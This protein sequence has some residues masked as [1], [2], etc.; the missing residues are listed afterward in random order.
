MRRILARKGAAAV[1]THATVRIHND[2][3]AG[4]ASVTVGSANHESAGRIDMVLGVRIHHIRRNDGVNHVLSHLLAQFF[5]GHAVV[6][7]RRNDHGVDPRRFAVDVF[8]T[9]LA[10][11]VGT[12][13][14][15]FT[16]A[17][18]ITEAA[19][20][21]V[22]QRNGQRHQFRR[23]V[24]SVSEHQALVAGAASVHAHRDIGRL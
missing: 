8:D 14:I 7:L 6:V 4:Q 22:C 23:F 21:L 16:A 12:K 11:A 17:A 24:T 5:G 19:S 18:H 13:K 9:H 10:F 3:A 2:F 20:K 1:T 15:Q